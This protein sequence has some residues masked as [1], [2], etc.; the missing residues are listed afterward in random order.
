MATALPLSSLTAVTGGAWVRDS[1]RCTKA[2]R[3]LR[4]VA[5]AGGLSQRG[6]IV[7]VAA[8]GGPPKP[9]SAEKKA[10]RA[11][12][13]A[14][15]AKAVGKR[16][17]ADDDYFWQLKAKGFA[18]EKPNVPTAVE[19]FGDKPAETA[20]AGASSSSFEIESETKVTRGGDVGKDVAAIDEFGDDFSALVPP[21]V[22][23]NLVGADRMRYRRP[24]P[25]QR[26]TVPLAL[27]GHDVLAS[28]QTG[29]VGLYKSSPVDTIA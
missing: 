22:F 19:L 4:S 21:W 6:T 18:R 2:S 29:S 11:G 9:A 12:K 14:A 13:Q 17:K 28:A 25:I 7:V 23:D 27:A 3:S 10:R 26:H 1:R 15:N 5:A 20:Q 8:S 24:S 16:L